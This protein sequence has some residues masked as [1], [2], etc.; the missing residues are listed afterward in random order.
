MRAN[1]R[2]ICESRFA[3]PNVLR[4]RNVSVLNCAKLSTKIVDN[5]LHA[6]LQFRE[7]VPPDRRKKRFHGDS[8]AA[9]RC[10]LQRLLSACLLARY[11]L[12]FEHFQR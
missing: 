6:W 7:V 2:L 8:C 4:P 5:Q 12:N 1:W 3:P 10:T 9:V 11:N